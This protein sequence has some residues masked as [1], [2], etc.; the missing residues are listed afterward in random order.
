VQGREQPL[1]ENAGSAFS[2]SKTLRLFQPFGGLSPCI[3][4]LSH[5]MGGNTGSHIRRYPLNTD[6][7]FSIK[8]YTSVL[9]WRG[10]SA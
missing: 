5:Q 9:I 10:M 2:N 8:F 7:V 6:S 3:F 1:P 4:L